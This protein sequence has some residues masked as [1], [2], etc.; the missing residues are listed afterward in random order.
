[1]FQFNNAAF[2]PQ[3]YAFSL[4]LLRPNDAHEHHIGNK[5]LTVIPVSNTKD[6]AMSLSKGERVRGGRSGAIPS[7]RR[8]FARE[9]AVGPFA[10]S[11]RSF[12]AV[13]FP[14][15]SLTRNARA[16]KTTRSQPGP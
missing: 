4:V 3:V 14:L 2:T 11:P 12:L 13:G 8:A 6:A 10:T 7:L 1:M 9:R 16:Y 5:L 15:L